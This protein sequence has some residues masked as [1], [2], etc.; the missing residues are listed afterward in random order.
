M[1]L[2]PRGEL[3][4]CQ[5]FRSESH[6]SI[7]RDFRLHWSTYQ[8]SHMHSWLISMSCRDQFQ[9]CRKPPYHIWEEVMCGIVP[10][11]QLYPWTVRQ[12]S[13]IL[14]NVKSRGSIKQIRT[15]QPEWRHFVGCI[16]SHLKSCSWHCTIVF[17]SFTNKK[18]I[19]ICHYLVPIDM[20]RNERFAEIKLKYLRLGIKF[21]PPFLKHQ[22]TG[23]ERNWSEKNSLGQIEFLSA[24]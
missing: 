3:K 5:A 10:V 11:S 7:T 8:E 23:N 24:Q 18:N 19:S 13:Y 12:V 6:L 15:L 16:C 22:I 2:E 17:I 14:C 21:S 1:I 4:R 9:L 20:Q